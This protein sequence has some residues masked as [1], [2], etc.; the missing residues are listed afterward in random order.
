METVQ[1]D[2]YKKAETYRNEHITKVDSYEEFK[3]VL[4]EKKKKLAADKEAA[5]KAKEEKT[6]TEKKE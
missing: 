5:K 1:N 3:K 6:E 2:I 4:E